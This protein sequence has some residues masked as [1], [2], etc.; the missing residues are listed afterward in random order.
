[1]RTKYHWIRRQCCPRPATN[2]QVCRPSTLGLPGSIAIYNVWSSKIGIDR[3]LSLVRVQLKQNLRRDDI[4]VEF[5]DELARGL[6]SAVYGN[7]AS[8]LDPTPEYI[9]SAVQHAVIVLEGRVKMRWRMETAKSQ[10]PFGPNAC[11]TRDRFN[12]LEHRTP[13]KSAHY[14]DFLT[15]TQRWRS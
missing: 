11:T 7:S 5:D 1:M 3:F 8:T 12:E 10:N 4:V 6:N 14:S 15:Q 13:N 9:T 2:H